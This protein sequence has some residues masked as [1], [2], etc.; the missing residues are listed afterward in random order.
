MQT[1]DTVAVI[2]ISSQFVLQVTRGSM[3]NDSQ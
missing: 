2:L 3:R 1:K